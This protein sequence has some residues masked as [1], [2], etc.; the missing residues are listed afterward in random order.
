M[1]AH[2]AHDP[3]GENLGMWIFLFTEIMLFGGF[4]VLYAAYFHRYPD[5]FVAAGARLDT[6]I[7]GINTV[8]LLV[9][10]FGVA[11]S[12][13]AIRTGGKRAAVCWL[14]MAIFLALIFLGNKYVEW[15]HKIHQDIFPGSATLS[16]GPPGENLFFALYYGVTG[17]HGLHVLIGMVLLSLSAIATY[18]GR[19]NQERYVLLDNC[20]LYWHLVDLIWIFVFPLFYLVP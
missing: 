19:I 13:T 16:E 4:F 8:I 2:S 6:M 18:T 1:S 3:V 9:S 17:L 12:I 11:A 10:S 15:G 20:G 5:S 14:L 7:G